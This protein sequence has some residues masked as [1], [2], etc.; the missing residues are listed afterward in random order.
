MTD[1]TP[2]SG[3]PENLAQNAPPIIRKRSYGDLPRPAMM[4]IATRD[5]LAFDNDRSNRCRAH[6]FTLY[7][8]DTGLA[9][10]G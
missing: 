2:L 10:P 8:P 4:T 1:Q 6:A 3:F 9:A 5:L 7:S